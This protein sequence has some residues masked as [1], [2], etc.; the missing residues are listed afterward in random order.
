M[1]C[2]IIA[3]Q[4]GA[5]DLPPVIERVDL[6][7]AADGVGQQLLTALWRSF[8]VLGKKIDAVILYQDD[9]AFFRL[10]FC[11]HGAQVG[12]FKT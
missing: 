10:S 1:F 9:A 12:T 6:R 5:G 4:L 3:T 7:I 8:T 11:K 2:E